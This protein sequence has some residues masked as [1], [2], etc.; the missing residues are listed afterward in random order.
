MEPRGRRH[1]GLDHAGASAR[2]PESDTSPTTATATATD[3]SAQPDRALPSR[4]PGLAGGSTPIVSG[5]S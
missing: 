1:P 2:V 3:G 5:A 4:G